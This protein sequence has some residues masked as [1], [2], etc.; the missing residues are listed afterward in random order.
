MDNS[1]YIINLYDYYGELLTEKQQR[2]F[3]DY[4]FNNLTL[5][6]IAENNSISRNAVH[7]QIKDVVIKLENYEAKLNLYQKGLKINEII[8]NLD[9]KIKEEI[10]ELI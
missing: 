4:Y 6:E 8:S 7:K 2:Y 9:E 1:F 10:K 5:S 3:E